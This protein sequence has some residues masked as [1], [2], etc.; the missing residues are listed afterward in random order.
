LDP[1]LPENPDDVARLKA[2]QNEIHV[3][4]IDL[5]K[6]SRGAR[7]KGDEDDLFSG[8]YWTG[9]KSIDLGLSDAIGDLRT[10]LR[11]RYGEKVK[12][13]LIAPA[14]GLLSGLFGRRSA[15]ME[16]SSLLDLPRAMPDELI[17]A[18]EARAIWARYG[19]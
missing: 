19:F 1:F 6:K 7:I 2:I 5:V 17:S 3:M 15:G 12:M 16:V 8:A 18:L 13:P 11:S 4:F 14:S 9:L 10:V